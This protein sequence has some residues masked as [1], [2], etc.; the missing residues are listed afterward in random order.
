MGGWPCFFE[1]QVLDIKKLSDLADTFNS[2]VLGEKGL[3]EAFIALG[4]HKL[5]FVFGHT[6]VEMY[7]S[8]GQRFWVALKNEDSGAEVRFCGGWPAKTADAVG[9]CN[10][11]EKD[12]RAM[13]ND[14][15]Q[16]FQPVKVSLG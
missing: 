9:D 12:I 8:K 11:S 2:K 4:N 7:K 13:V 1:A 10:G 5:A 14:L 16:N 6:N 3:R 15:V